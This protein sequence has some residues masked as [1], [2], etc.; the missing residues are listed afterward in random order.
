MLIIDVHEFSLNRE[1]DSQCKQLWALF[2]FA[3]NVAKMALT[4]VAGDKGIS[5][6]KSKQQSPYSK[7]MHQLVMSQAD[8]CTSQAYACIAHDITDWCMRLL[9]GL[10]CFDFVSD[11]PLSLSTLGV[12]SEWQNLPWLLGWHSNNQDCFN[13]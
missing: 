9:H 2:A 4:K 6:T 10:C 1:F 12:D 3:N 11:I 8:T 5:E 7:S 13:L